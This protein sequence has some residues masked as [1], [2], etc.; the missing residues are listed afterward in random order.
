MYDKMLKDVVKGIMPDSFLEQVRIVVFRRVLHFHFASKVVPGTFRR[1]ME[2]AAKRR[3]LPVDP[4]VTP[5]KY[6][7]AFVRMQLSDP[8]DGLGELQ[9]IS[10][11]NGEF[12][13]KQHQLQWRRATFCLKRK[14]LRYGIVQRVKKELY[15]KKARATS[16]SQSIMSPVHPSIDLNGTWARVEVSSRAKS[17]YAWSIVCC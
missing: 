5:S 2:F 1:P 6:V 13:S 4:E 15:S 8:S 10:T 7:A 3:Y 12:K 17:A 9:D 14:Q 11:E 16:L